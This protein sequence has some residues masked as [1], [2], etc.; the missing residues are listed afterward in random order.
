MDYLRAYLH[1]SAV[2]PRLQLTDGRH[3]CRGHGF[4][5]VVHTLLV[6][7]SRSDAHAQVV[8]TPLLDIR[9]RLG[10]GGRE[11]IVSN[12]VEPI[13]DDG[14]CGVRLAV[15]FPIL[16]I[17]GLDVTL[18]VLSHTVFDLIVL[19]RLTTVHAEAKLQ[20]SRGVIGDTWLFL[21][22]LFAIGFNAALSITKRGSIA[23]IIIDDNIGS[24]MGIGR[25]RSRQWMS[26][27]QK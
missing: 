26:F 25:R 20:V 4:R 13:Q 17:A 2:L 5:G 15:V 18:V 22:W 23:I 24:F 6:N 1:G 21:F 14:L 3:I 19:D 11:V 16:G 7:H 9:S 12:L 10:V 8:Q 27:E